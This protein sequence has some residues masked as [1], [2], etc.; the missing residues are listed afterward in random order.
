[1]QTVLGFVAERLNIES[2]NLIEKYDDFVFNLPQNKSIM[3]PIG[4][5]TMLVY[6][7]R[8]SKK[9]SMRDYYFDNAGEAD[10]KYAYFN[11]VK[12]KFEYDYCLM[13]AV[14]N[15]LVFI[16]LGFVALLLGFAFAVNSSWTES[17]IYI[18]IPSLSAIGTI[19]AS[20]H[21]YNMKIKYLENI[22]RV[23]NEYDYKKRNNIT[24]DGPASALVM[25]SLQDAMF[26]H[27]INDFIIPEFISKHYD[28]KKIK[29]ANR[30]A[31]L[32]SETRKPVKKFCPQA[33]KPAENA[34]TKETKSEPK[35]TLPPTAV[36]PK[37]QEKPAEKHIQ[38]KTPAVSANPD[39]AVRIKIPAP[40]RTKL[41]TEAAP[42][43]DKKTDKSG[44]ESKK[45]RQIKA[46]TQK[47][48]TAKKPDTANIPSKSQ[49]N[50]SAAE[51]N[52]SP[53]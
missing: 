35:K 16:W 15:F 8:Y 42:V 40:P 22:L 37:A 7:S 50:K 4:D 23:I 10:D 33:V 49:R 19:A 24:A 36:K 17:V 45:V 14:K 9:L 51:S 53:R 13:L 38:N 39:T 32:A 31:L 3:R 6:N 1:M 29:E 2:V 25:R 52:K 20:W 34:K 21:N 11:A 30:L 44:I 12:K 26:T 18:F 28:R 47:K 27:R 48:Q 41:K 5:Q 46:E 43:P